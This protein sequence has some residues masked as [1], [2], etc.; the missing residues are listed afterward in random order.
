MPFVDTQRYE[1]LDHMHPNIPDGGQRP[2]ILYKAIAEEIL[3]TLCQTWDIG[4]YI[5]FYL[6]EVQ[7]LTF[8]RH[9]CTWVRA[10]AHFIRNHSFIITRSIHQ[11]EVLS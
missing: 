10:S 2:E 6:Q 8:L 4:K 3:C 9:L 1:M 5:E 11:K 7:P